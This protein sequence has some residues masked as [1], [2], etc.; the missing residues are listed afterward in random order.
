M[1][2]AKLSEQIDELRGGDSN[3]VVKSLVSMVLQIRAHMNAGRDA[4]LRAILMDFIIEHSLEEAREILA[5]FKCEHFTQALKLNSVDFSLLIRKLKGRED[6]VVPALTPYDLLAEL[7]VCW[8]KHPVWNGCTDP[9][10]IFCGA[11]ADFLIR[12]DAALE[13]GKSNG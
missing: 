1:G 4:K 7:R 2:K 10:C 6:P 5:A 3:G 12:V 8:A 13:K 9:E 11:K